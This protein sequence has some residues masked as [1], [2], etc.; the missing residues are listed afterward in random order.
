MDKCVSHITSIKSSLIVCFL[1]LISCKLVAQVLPSFDN[2][3]AF[4]KQVEKIKDSSPNQ[5]FRVLMDKYQLAE[6]L[7]V[8]K[9]L[10]YYRILSEIYVEQANYQLSKTTADKALAQARTLQN[11]SITTSEL[12]YARGFAN[13]SL[14]DYQAARE[15]YLNGHEIAKSLNNQK[16]SA[17][18][19][20]N[21]GA[22]DYLTEQFD[23]SLVM[24]NDALAIANDIN[25]DEL[26]GYINGE[27]GI[28]YSLIAQD[29][30]S[31]AFYQKAHQYYLKAGKDYYAF[32][33][34]RNIAVN[35]SIEEKYEKSITLYKEIIDNKDK[36]ANN[37]LI[38]AVYSGMAWAH[39]RKED[40]NPEAAYEYMLIASQYIEDAEQIDAP[41]NHALDKG[42][43]LMELERYD[44]AITHLEQ[45]SEY[46]KRY[47]NSEQKMMTTMSRLDILYLKAE[48]YFK[49][50][51][52]KLAYSAQEE[53]LD[54]VLSL[55]AKN[56]VEEVEDIRMRYESE[57]ADLEKKILK[58]KDAVQ[59]LQIKET[60]ESL[61]QRQV[62]IVLFSLVALVL[63]WVLINIIKGQRQ[64]L[65]ASRTDVLTGINNRRRLMQLL[66]Q[67]HSQAKAQQ[68]PLSLVM[69]DIDNFKEINDSFGHQVGDEVLC[70]IASFGENLM[71]N[72]DEFGR[73]GGEEFIVILPRTNKEQAIAFAERIRTTVNGHGW[74]I[75]GLLNVSLSIGVATFL[76]G[77]E[78]TVEALLKQTDQLLYRAKEQ[79]KDQVCYDS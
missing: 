7:P 59:A 2:F 43:L 73:F 60:Q 65:N 74:H 49:L 37:E 18:G 20:V 31:L 14:G 28:L 56:N 41:L 47:E 9:R 16:F 15:D 57:Q 67:M 3:N 36:I 19:L 78:L 72:G 8:E 61:N 40:K 22:L 1:L 70:K 42:Y 46:F 45:A 39:V 30:K 54:F 63:A 38:A 68:E 13:E 32:N 52:Y 62:F 17:M 69:L 58:Q 26:L 24:F 34:L 10:V 23:R 76:A 21:L 75:E 48:V 29:E 66:E 11:P 55:P 53:Y 44:E 79:G 33:T 27:L 35:Y 64:L 50:K 5:A 77:Q 51:N 6:Q 12:L 71:R 25:D 4:I